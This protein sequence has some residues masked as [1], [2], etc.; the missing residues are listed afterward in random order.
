[1]GSNV[2][3]GCENVENIFALVDCNNFYVSCERVFA[4][5]LI[6]R[7]RDFVVEVNELRVSA[8]AGFVVVI[9]GEIMTMPGLP[10]R[11]AA[12][13]IDVDGEGTISGLF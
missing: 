9:C 8:G 4:P 1:M 6:G 10:R 11:P 2:Q 13:D 3:A 12:L 5:R 7:P